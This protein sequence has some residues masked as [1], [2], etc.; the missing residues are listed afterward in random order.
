VNSRGLPLLVVAAVGF[1][2]CS[3]APPPK[4]AAPARVEAPAVRPA[5][6]RR[7]TVAVFPFENNAITGRE[8]LDFLREWLPDAIAGR[9]GEAGELKVVERRELLRL[10][11]EQKL[12]ASELASKE[13]RLEIGK[14][15]G[16]QTMVFGGFT[17]IGDRLMIDARLVDS[18]SGVVLKSVSTGGA[19]A[20]ARQVAAE[21]CGL[22]AGGLGLE[23]ARRSVETGLENER[24]LAAV[25]LYYQALA[26]EKKGETDGAI[27]GYRR[28]LEIDKSDGEARERLKKL[29]QAAP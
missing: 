20:D 7:Q 27:D 26:L 19:A 10:L 17:A 6:R 22:L 29:L 4:P 12:G 9:L 11:Q 23:A 25:E 5:A 16:A 2:A 1:G 15:A 13:G 18:E 3:S 24:S 14:I 8:R 21:L 28:V